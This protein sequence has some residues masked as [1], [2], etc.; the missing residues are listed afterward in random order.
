MT[1][2]NL[3]AAAAGGIA[4]Y[5]LVNGALGVLRLTPPVVKL[6][7][8]T[9]GGPAGR[10][11]T[12]L[13]ALINGLIGPRTS[14]R[15][16]LK[17]AA[18]GTVLSTAIAAIAFIASL[19]FFLTALGAS[20]GLW[21]FLSRFVLSQAVIAFVVTYLSYTALGLAAARIAM[22][23]PARLV[24][25]VLIDMAVK[26]LLSA[27]ISAGI[28]AAYARLAGSFG[29][30]WR[31]AIAVVPDTMLSAAHFDNFTGVVLYGV[32]AS[33]FPLFLALGM[34][35][36]EPG[37]PMAATFRRIAAT[38]AMLAATLSLLAAG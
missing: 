23:G 17:S 8:G 31:T 2:A 33:G 15:Q 34:R 21:A 25:F 29:G 27:A 18:V 13:F 1:P 22:A 3:A 32:L 4:V 28:Y 5:G 24:A 10:T 9:G 30:S 36:G 38:F 26:A 12:V 14:F 35:A 6:L 20:G 37:E 11:E 19:P 16:F 7:P